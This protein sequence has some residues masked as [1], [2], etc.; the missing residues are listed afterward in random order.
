MNIK[1]F[2]LYLTEYDKIASGISYL[3][4]IIFIFNRQ[5]KYSIRMEELSHTAQIFLQATNKI[6]NGLI[7]GLPKL[8]GA[9]VIVLIGWVLAKLLVLIIGKILKA[10]K[11][12]SI[13][14]KLNIDYFLEKAN[15]KKTPI[16]IIKLF[17]YYF[18]MLIVLITAFEVL[19][20][21][22]ITREIHKLLAFLP[23]L[24]FA[25]LFF[26]IG[27]Y[28]A[29]LIKS[30]VIGAGASMGMSAGKILG[31]V[32]FYFLMIM[33]T[34][35]SLE[36]MEVDISTIK[37]NLMIIIA[38]IVS[39]GAISYGLAS[40]EVLSNIL[41]TYYNRNLFKKDM[42]IEVEGFKG[43]IIEVNRLG[44]IL[45]LESGEKINIPSKKLISENVRIFE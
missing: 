3:L 31:N 24:L 42:M 29:S 11:F 6:K 5:L 40:R 8:F 32:L 39:A 1:E 44:V 9:V 35:S 43:T 14:E 37:S 15:F 45:L 7:E 12:N 27:A 30:V 28:I 23:K 4:S 36:Q 2:L 17:V 16:D 33:I 10:V 20:A 21:D 25:V 18:V 26:T 19:G 22:S 38:A 13:T 34:L 41:A